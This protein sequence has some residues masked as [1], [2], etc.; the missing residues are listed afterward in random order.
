[1]ASLKLT[2]PYVAVFL[3]LGLQPLFQEEISL[4]APEGIRHQLYTDPRITFYLEPNSNNRG[5]SFCN[6][7]LKTIVH[8]RLG[9]IKETDGIIHVIKRENI[10]NK[11]LE[12]VSDT[13][14]HCSLWSSNHGFFPGE[15]C[16]KGK[17]G[18]VEVTFKDGTTWQLAEELTRLGEKVKELDQS[19][20]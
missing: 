8:Y 16:K 1:M 6:H 18:V 9:C 17:L 10:E 11:E 5:F 13:L 12:G 4:I 15:A 3:L 14:F 2:V 7:S 20:E 19:E